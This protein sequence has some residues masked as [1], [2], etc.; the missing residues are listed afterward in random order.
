M[1]RSNECFGSNC[2]AE[3]CPCPFLLISSLTGLAADLRA[4][5]DGKRLCVDRDFGQS[6]VALV[7]EAPV[8]LGS[9]AEA[10]L[11]SAAIVYLSPLRW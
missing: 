11:G 8:G 10:A 3:V 7:D 9:T 5:C 2:L 1:P 6:G 4:L